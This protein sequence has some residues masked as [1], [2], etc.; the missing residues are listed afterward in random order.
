MS[1][2]SG[3]HKIKHLMT[4]NFH[5]PRLFKVSL[6]WLMFV[7]TKI[8]YSFSHP[9][10]PTLLDSSRVYSSETA[11]G[12]FFFQFYLCCLTGFPG[13][14]LFLF[15]ISAYC[16]IPF[17]GAVIT[18]YHTLGSLKNRNLFP[19]RSRGLKSKFKVPAGLC[20]LRPQVDSSLSCSYLLVVAGSPWHTLP[21]NCIT[22]L[23]ASVI[24]SFSLGVCFHMEFPL[25]RTSLILDWASL[26]TQTVK[27]PRA[28][29]D[30]QVQS[31]RQED[32]L[33]KGTATHSSIL[34]WRIPLTEE[35][36]R[37]QTMGS[38][39]QLSN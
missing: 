19:P 11:F 31:L 23:P 27:N 35:P 24:T 38:Q 1:N 32:P 12:K 13:T 17:P 7:R 37:L 8:F 26:V 18:E 9:W 22:P 2:A 28:I 4:G 20:S 10:V 30:T 39:T 33:K 29:Q 34:A 3:S 15:K 25:R 36:A 21:C 16:I 5:Y 14:F 6:Q